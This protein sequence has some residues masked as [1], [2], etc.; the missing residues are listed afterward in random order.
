MD[1]LFS[2]PFWKKK[3]MK[4]GFYCS[5]VGGQVGDFEKSFFREIFNF[6][7]FKPEKGTS[8][9]QARVITYFQLFSKFRDFQEMLQYFPKG[10][11][12]ASTFFLCWEKCWFCHDLSVILC[13]NWSFVQKMIKIQHFAVNYGR[14][15]VIDFRNAKTLPLR[16][17]FARF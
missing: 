12:F 5:F 15:V 13:E 9:R 16:N 17:C 6:S 7:D 8:R 4:R 10:F 3:L 1:A 14:I 2:L 11:C